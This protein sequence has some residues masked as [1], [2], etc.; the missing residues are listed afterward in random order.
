MLPDAQAEWLQP[1]NPEDLDGPMG[2]LV[3]LDFLQLA[4]AEVSGALDGAQLPMLKSCAF[5][6]SC[7]ADVCGAPGPAAAAV[8]AGASKAKEPP[9][10]GAPSRPGVHASFI[11]HTEAGMRL[12][13]NVSLDMSC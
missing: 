4:V 1:V 7:A 13:S 6:F 3:M 10:Q 11:V 8:L 12:L 9:V 2:P 5:R